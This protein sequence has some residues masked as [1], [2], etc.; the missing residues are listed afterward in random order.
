MPPCWPQ[1]AAD[2][3]AFLE[4]RGY[5]PVHLVA[6]SYGTLVASALVKRSN[7][8]HHDGDDGD[9]GDAGEKESAQA[10]GT[11]AEE[12]G[13]AAGEE[14]A[15][16]ELGG[17]AAAQAAE[18]E[19]APAADK[20]EEEGAPA[21]RCQV[22]GLT[23]LDPVCFAM[24]LPNLLRNSL[25]FHVPR[26]AHAAPAPASPPPPPRSSS[27]V[28]DA[29]AAKRAAPSSAPCSFSGVPHHPLAA[30]ETG[31]QAT[32][33][34]LPPGEASA[35][36]AASWSQ[37]PPPPP[38]RGGRAPPPPAR[39][40]NPLRGVVVRDVH[41]AV[42]LSR[43]TQW[44]EVNLWVRDLPRRAPTTVV[45]SGDDH[46]VPVDAVLRMLSSEAAAQRGVKVQVS[47]VA[48]S[49]AL[50]TPHWRLALS[51]PCKPRRV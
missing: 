2:V 10:T 36:S 18:E 25:F 39:R 24:Y 41:V 37:P 42:A 28:A 47:V 21:A 6:H 12:G 13:A 5:G 16:A 32:P 1:V 23:L 38:P 4:A 45:V 50:G 26:A 30:V 3:E 35:R 19:I 29:A 34:A 33:D 14:V 17:G 31:D 20:E 11:A 40:W 44:S 27:P 8:R 49:A 15:P 22:A 51:S 46:M 43:R 48:A 9:G 7:E